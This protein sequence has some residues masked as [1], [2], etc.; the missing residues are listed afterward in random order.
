MIA[1]HTYPSGIKQ[2]Y[3]MLFDSLTFASPT[4]LRRTFLAAMDTYENS[5]MITPPLVDGS[6][7]PGHV[8]RR[9]RRVIAEYQDSLGVPIKPDT[10]TVRNGSLVKYGPFGVACP[11]C[12]PV[13]P[14][15]YVYEPR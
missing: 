2:V 5:R 13:R 1:T 12:M 11:T 10:F 15:E 9:G 4:V 3:T 7:Y 14:V 6:S 8:V